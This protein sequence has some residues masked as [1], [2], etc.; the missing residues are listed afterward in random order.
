[1]IYKL[2]KFKKKIQKIINLGE[3]AEDEGFGEGGGVDG[4]GCPGGDAGEVV[5]VGV[6]EEMVA[7]AVGL[8][9]PRVHREGEALGHLDRHLA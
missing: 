3:V 8:W 4:V 6:G 2:G 5:P 9:G 7:L 1:M